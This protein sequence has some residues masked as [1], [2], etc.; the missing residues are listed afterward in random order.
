LVLTGN[1]REDEGRMLLLTQQLFGAR[2]PELGRSSAAMADPAQALQ[3]FQ[4]VLGDFYAYFRALTAERRRAPRDDV[5]SIIAN[6][7]INGEPIADHEANS[8]YIL[9]ATAGHDT[10]SASTSGAMMT[11]AQDPELLRTVQANPALIGNLV[12]EAIRW[13][14]PVKHFMRSA[15]RDCE[16][17]G[18]KIRQGDWLMLSYMSANRDEAVFPEPFAFRLDRDGSSNLAFGQGAHLCLGQHLAKLEMR[19]LFEELLP[20]IKELRLDG[21]PVWTQSVFISGPKHLPIAFLT[22]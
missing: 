3:V 21:K 16:L 15:T 22:H 13:T 9:L 17:A 19:I 8:Y 4:A 18:Q 2:D 14:T 10:T 5:A 1:T 12:D 6:A 11:L 20:H 7:V